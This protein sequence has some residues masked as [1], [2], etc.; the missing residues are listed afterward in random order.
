MYDNQDSYSKYLELIRKRYMRNGII[1]LGDL[2]V[3]Q[4]VYELVAVLD[5]LESINQKLAIATDNTTLYMMN[6]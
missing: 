1:E 5:N 6:E 3:D 2:N 4:N